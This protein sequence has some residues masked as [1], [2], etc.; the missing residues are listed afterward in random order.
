MGKLTRMI[1]GVASVA[2]AAALIAGTVTM[3]SAAPND[4]PKGVTPAAYDIVGV[5]SNTT[6]YVMD[7]FSVAYNKTVK[8]H[9]VN[10]P[11]FYSYD[12]L[13]LGVNVPG[14]YKIKP[15]AGCATIARP[16]GSGAGVTALDTTQAIKFNGGSYQ[17][18]DFARSS[19][20]RKP[21][22]PA[23]KPGGIVFVAFAKDAITWAARSAAKGG[24]NAPASLTTAQLKAIFTCKDTNWKQV[25]G[26][27][28]AI[29]VYL[30]QAGSGTLSTWEKFM[31][32]TTLGACVSQAPEENEGT[33]AG[34]NNPNAIFIWSI[35]A[36]VAQ[37][38]H[39]AACGKAPTKSQNQFGC[40]LTGF[41]V[42]EKISGVN[43]LS[44]G[45][46]PTINS[47]FPAS[48]W[49]TVYNVV[50]YWTGTADHLSPKDNHIFGPKSQKGYI[51]SNAA[52]QTTIKDYGFVPS[53]LCGSTS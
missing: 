32:I 12:A 18:I 26:K 38:Y 19:G 27:S 51:C 15:K 40:N 43:P 11:K 3:A 34:F 44:A 14:N 24:T 10:N 36:Y 52:A 30:P 9:N 13:P 22:N 42:P 2:A 4:P 1:A 20:G 23:E 46:L 7:A 33:Y 37:K 25:G 47:K 5:G 48:Y 50:K 21:T 35:G 29:K 45:K 41:I 53:G 6:Q 39:S 28:G 31:G 16:D 8:T 49:R 17:C